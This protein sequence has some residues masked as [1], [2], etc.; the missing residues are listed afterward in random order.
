MESIFEKQ[1]KYTLNEVV[2]K[3]GKLLEGTVIS[4]DIFIPLKK[5]KI[6]FV[7]KVTFDTYSTQGSYCVLRVKVIETNTQK[8]EISLNLNISDKK[9]GSDSRFTQG[10]AGH[11]WTYD[12]SFYG[13]VPD[14]NLIK[15]DFNLFLDLQGFK[16]K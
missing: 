2:E 12:D 10:A 13:Y 3:I 5:D 16:R 8:S 15:K 6:D 14:F 9:Y 1:K 4:K 7:A 11:F